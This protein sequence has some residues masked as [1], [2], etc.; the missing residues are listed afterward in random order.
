MFSVRF[1]VVP[2]LSVI[3]TIRENFRKFPP[4]VKF[5]EILEPHAYLS[6]IDVTVCQSRR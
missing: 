3:F 1:T 2:R 5:P 4:N 6:L